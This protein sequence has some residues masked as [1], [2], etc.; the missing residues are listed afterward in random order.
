MLADSGTRVL[1]GHRAAAAGL[2]GPDGDLPGGLTP[3]WLD[4]PAVAATLAAATVGPPARAVSPGQLAYLIYTSGSTGTPKGVEVT[5]RSVVNYVA[6]CPVAYPG[7]A[8][9]TLLHAPLAFDAVVTV[10]YGALV[11]GGCVHVAALDEDL[12]AARERARVGPYTFLKVTPALL[13]TLTSLPAACS[14]T[15]ELMVGGDLVRGEDL[16]RW[17]DRNPGVTVVAHYGPTETTVGSTDYPIDAGHPAVPGVVPVGRP[18]WNTQVYVLDRGLRPVPAGV[19]GE[20]YIG[21]TGLARGYHNRPA[22]TA[23]RFLADPFGPAGAR[24]YRTGDRVRWRADGVARLPRPGRRPGRRS[25]ATGS[26]RAR[27]RPSWR[28]TRG[29]GRRSWWPTGR[30]PTLGWSATWC[31]PPAR[32]APP[33]GTSCATTCASGCP[34]SWSRPR[35][36]NWLPSR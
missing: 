8:G 24:M 19:P 21:G 20:L 29:C 28:P 32:R 2:V 6:R 25:A 4:D 35:S 30:A 34:S 22:L 13:P 11:S 26:S 36:W 31:P 10:L 33:A 27:S 12:A 7:L 23:E 3:L 5:H 14:P 16:Q 18:M 15:G 17:R 1:V 9:V